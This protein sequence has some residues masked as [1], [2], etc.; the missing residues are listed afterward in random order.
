ML[1]LKH[2][3]KWIRWGDYN[4]TFPLGQRCVQKQVPSCSCRGCL[5]EKQRFSAYTEEETLL[6]ERCQ[7]TGGWRDSLSEESLLQGLGL[8]PISRVTGEK[9]KWRRLLLTLRWFFFHLRYRLTP[10][11]EGRSHTCHYLWLNA[12]RRSYP[13]HYK[14]LSPCVSSLPSTTLL[15]W[16]I[17]RSTSYFSRMVMNR[18]Q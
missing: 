2:P 8:R 1:C 13:A 12:V 10:C 7:Q 6:E 3:L 4:G 9:W 5:E 14:M 15:A 16:S 17:F 11:L 18:S